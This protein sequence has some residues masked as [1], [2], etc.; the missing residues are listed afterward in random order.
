MAQ[1]PCK[2][3]HHFQTIHCMFA[4]RELK[5]QAVK[6]SDIVKSGKQSHLK[7]VCANWMRRTKRFLL[8]NTIS[9]TKSQHPEPPHDV[10]TPYCI[11]L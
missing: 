7:C 3:L 5:A 2:D 4:N 6:A 10:S 11:A 8:K 1:L 9:P